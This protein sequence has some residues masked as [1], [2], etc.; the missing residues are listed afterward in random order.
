MP[1]QDNSDV[2]RKRRAEGPS[3]W[4]KRAVGERALV[5]MIVA[6]VVALFSLALRPYHVFGRA[7]LYVFQRSAQPVQ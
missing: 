5:W 2:A 1:K 3:F 4:A 6:Y 7:G